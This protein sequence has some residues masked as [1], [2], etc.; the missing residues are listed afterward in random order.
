MIRLSGNTISINSQASSYTLGMSDNAG[1]VDMVSGSALTVTVPRNITAPFAIGATIS[2]RQ[3]GAGQ[4][5]VAAFDGT[6][7]INSVSGL[8]LTAQYG[9]ASLVKIS[10]NTWT[11]TG[12]LGA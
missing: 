8:K 9:I 5:T 10:T 12:P 4:V 2:I 1:L 7:I 3:G 6:V 11:I